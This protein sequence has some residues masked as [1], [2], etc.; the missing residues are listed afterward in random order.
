MTDDPASGFGPK[1]EDG[2]AR[3]ERA[4]GVADTMPMEVG[5]AGP[6]EAMVELNALLGRGTR[7]AGKLWFEGRIRIEGQFEGE[8][9]GQD[10]LVIGAGAEVE[11]DIEVGVCIVTG[12]RVRAGI[13]AYH[14]IELH[15]PAVVVG[16]MHAPNIF[17][18]RGV[19][20]EGNCKMAPLGEREPPRA[21]PPPED[22]R[23]A[24]EPELAALSP[25]AD[26]DEPVALDED[27]RDHGSDQDV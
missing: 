9:R 22:E 27:A 17:I 1:A 11:G 6:N 25:S 5:G 12:G 7:Y 26:D 8:I 20:F 13:R 10:V 21:A 16:D 4:G 3:T 14:A 19:T 2:P 23:A 15:A 18:D 24:T